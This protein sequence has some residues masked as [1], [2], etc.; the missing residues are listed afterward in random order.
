[1][2]VI[3]IISL[4][5]LLIVV[6][7][8]ILSLAELRRKAR[9]DAEKQTEEEKALSRQAAKEK[10]QTAVV[11]N[12]GDEPLEEEQTDISDNDLNK[13]KA[14]Y[15]KFEKD[16]LAWEARLQTKSDFSV[17]EEALIRKEQLKYRMYF[18]EAFYEKHGNSVA[19][20]EWRKWTDAFSGLLE[21]HAHLIV[22]EEESNDE[23][24]ADWTDA[25]ETEILGRTPSEKPQ[26]NLDVDRPSE[27]NK[28]VEALTE[29]VF[30]S[31]GRGAD[32]V[33]IAAQQTPKQEA[34]AVVPN[35]AKENA[36]RAAAF[37]A[38]FAAADAPRVEIDE[39]GLK[40]R[41]RELWEY[42]N[43]R[44]LSKREAGDRYERYLG[45]LYERAGW[46]VEY[47]GLTEGVSNSNRGIDLICE[48]DAITHFVQTKYWSDGV[49][50]K[51][52]VNN[53][54]DRIVKNMQSIIDKRAI[55]GEVQAV[56]AAKPKLSAQVAAYA[57]EQGV[58]LLDNLTLQPYPLVKCHTGKRGSKKYF[59]PFL[60]DKKPA[61]YEEIRQ[62]AWEPYDLVH[63]DWGDGD[64][65]VHT[66]KEAEA[67]GYK[68]SNRA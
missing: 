40:G 26:T 5:V 7:A 61:K 22:G 1:M 17:G 23:D 37:P 50:A 65:Y 9:L 3:L 48:K 6:L 46:R 45:Y 62:G 12:H 58:L 68:Y 36:L 54:I 11:A 55:C 24:E 66:I 8:V 34:V 38:D 14:A 16:V 63:M 29:T 44:N 60:R 53:V 67:L 32:K 57:Q 49:A 39:D 42:A 64:V 25:D 10:M 28:A 27:S 21:R 13:I 4:I 41:E 51:T 56:L 31:S 20:Q 33:E 2:D 35:G 52:N 30:S 18:E 15:A 47:Y 19:S 59:L 43:R